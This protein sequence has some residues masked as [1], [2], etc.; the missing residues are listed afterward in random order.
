MNP[1]GQEEWDAILDRMIFCFTEMNEVTCSM[2]NE[3]GDDYWDASEEIDIPNYNEKGKIEIIKSYTI[4]EPDPELEKLYHNRE[5]EI[6]KYREDMKNEGFELF[7][8]YF[9]CLWY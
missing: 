3:Y 1:N 2:E 9:W 5:N 8:K 7:S 6:K 4:R